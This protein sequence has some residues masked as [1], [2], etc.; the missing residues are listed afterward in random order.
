[1]T[2]PKFE[3]SALARLDLLESWNY[4]A[5][6]ASLDHA[7]RIIGDIEKAIQQLTKSPHDGHKRTD[8]TSRDVLFCRVHSYLIVYRPKTTP[9]Q[10]V[11]VLHVSRDAAQLLDE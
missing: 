1:M 9:L 5:E 3:L 11:R 2:N 7:D 6:N 4:L 8:L 10:I